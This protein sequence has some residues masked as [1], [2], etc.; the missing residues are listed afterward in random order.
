[1][2]G[3]VATSRAGCASGGDDRDVRFGVSL[4]RRRDDDEAMRGV[5]D[6]TRIANDDTKK[7]CIDRQH[8][9]RRLRSR[10]VNIVVMQSRSC[11]TRDANT[12]TNIRRSESRALAG[13][14]DEQAGKGRVK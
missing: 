4:A 13:C 11:I 5:F 1:V 6:S 3:A 8:R 9:T 12:R 7:K 10:L 2:S 14:T